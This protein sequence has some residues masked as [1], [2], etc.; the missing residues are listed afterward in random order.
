MRRILLTGKNGQV[1]WELQHTLATLGEV[2]AVDRNDVDLADADAIRR[3]VRQTK[4]TVIVNAAAYTAVD[5]AESEPELAM[6]VNGTAPGILAEEAKH[7]G[8]AIVHYSTDYVF[9]GDKKTPYIEEDI[10]NPLNV[11]GNSKLAGERAIRSVAA[12]HLIFR[13][14]WVYGARRKNFLMT[15]LRLAREKKELKIVDDQFGAPTWCRAIAEATAQILTRIEEAEGF[16][17]CSGTYH[18]SAAGQTSWR[19][20]AD[21]IVQTAGERLSGERPTLASV[22][23]VPIRT[24]EL[25]LP[26]KR[27]ANSLLSNARLKEVF[28]VTMASWTE[29]LRFC[30]EDMKEGRCLSN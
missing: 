24:S 16:P 13:T 11:Y 12:P 27:P 19:G 3:I 1:G 21:E 18:L 2:T 8:A 28:G 10:P 6:A 9:D 7:L 30:C 14:S 17:N 25:P 23:I 5:Q 22:Q 15:I 29:G 4:P 20:F 26:A